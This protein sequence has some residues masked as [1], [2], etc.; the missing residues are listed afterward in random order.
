[1]NLWILHS[2]ADSYGSRP[3]EI[4]GVETPWGAYQLD[5]VTLLTGRAIQKKIDEGHD[6]FAV[7]PALQDVFRN[8]HGKK[9]IKKVRVKPD[10]TW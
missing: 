3:S 9:G 2:L 4:L 7:Q 1:V 10:G 5:V 6:P 8:P